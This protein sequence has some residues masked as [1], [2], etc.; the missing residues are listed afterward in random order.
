MNE[1]PYR[2]RDHTISESKHTLTHVHT[3]ICDLQNDEI[4]WQIT[5]K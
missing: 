3:Q 5:I 2:R 1:S 4:I